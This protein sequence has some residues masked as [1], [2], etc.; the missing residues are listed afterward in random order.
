MVETLIGALLPVVF[1][2]LF[3]YFAG[4]IGA[5]PKSFTS[6]LNKLVMSFAL[7]LSLF[8]SINQMSRQL[9]ANNWNIA[10]WQFGGMMIWWL[11]VYFFSRFVLK[12]GP[13]VSPIRAMALATPAILFV[14]PALLEPLYKTTGTIAVSIGGMMM[15]VVMLPLTAIVLSANDTKD[16]KRPSI[17][18]QLLAGLKKPVVFAPIIGLITALLGLHLPVIL[19]ATF[20]ELG[21][22]AAGGGLFSIG[23]VLYFNKPSFSLAVWVDVLFKEVLIPLSIF[24]AL[25]L[26]GESTDFV[27]QTTLTFMISQMIFPTI[28]AQQYGEGERE[29]ASAIFLTTITSFFVMAI[30]MV[31]RGMTL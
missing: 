8:F 12:S 26:A 19:E 22:A 7:P 13:I 2:V 5:F 18:H 3:G 30:F 29:M 16:G 9:L 1:T 27:N 20:L 21:K 17:G 25:L 11:I 6:L 23:L 14:G 28:F 10:A 31:A 4:A 15:N 24:A